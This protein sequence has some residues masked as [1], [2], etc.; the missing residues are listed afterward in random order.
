MSKSEITK[1]VMIHHYVERKK[2]TKEIAQLL[3][4]SISTVKNYLNKHEIPR[5]KKLTFDIVEETIQTYNPE[6]KLLSFETNVKPLKIKC[7]CGNEFE[8]LLGV[9]KQGKS[10]LCFD[11]SG[12]RG[13]ANK[14]T[15][16][17]VNDFFAQTECKLLSSYVDSKEDISILCSCGD[18]F[19][20]TFTL[21]KSGKNRMCCKCLIKKRA[22]SQTSSIAEVTKRIEDTGC[23]WI[24][25]EYENQRSKLI[26]SCLQC[27]EPYKVIFEKFIFDNQVRCRSCSKSKSGYELYMEGI[28]TK[29]NI[30]YLNDKNLEG[31]VGVKGGQLRFDFII[32]LNNAHQVV[33]EVDGMQHFKDG[34]NKAFF[35]NKQ[36]FELRKENDRLKEQYCLQHKIPLLR[37]SYDMF[38]SFLRKKIMEEELLSFIESHQSPQAIIKHVSSKSLNLIPKKGRPSKQ[39]QLA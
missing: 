7:S 33:V 11:C 5:R 18:V 28:L 12:Y 8:R 36:S 9:I 37:I 4:C 39:L 22:K 24:S 14:Y 2:S 34:G 32:E 23:H 31:A 38:K 3:G 16:E 27:N 19:V 25:G 13:P 21:Y 10:C 17:E 29:H 35:N 20:T 26:I 1:D 30:N 15:L 6:A